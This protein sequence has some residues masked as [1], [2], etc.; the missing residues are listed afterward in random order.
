MIKIALVAVVSICLLNTVKSIRGDFVPFIII[1]IAGFIM[2]TM[3]GS[4][5]QVVELLNRFRN[6]TK[7]DGNYFT[8]LIKMIGIAYVAEF[9]SGICRDC[10]YGGIASQVE[11]A[12]KTII[13]CMSFP[14]IIALLDTI[15]LFF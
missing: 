9:A 5:G 10:G 1:I 8:T 6:Y 7:I 3:A 13:M 15:V 12:G 11:M 14:I 2:W 4:F